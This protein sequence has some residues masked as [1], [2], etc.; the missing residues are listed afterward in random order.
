[1]GLPF[2]WGVSRIGQT[3][4]S[5]ISL[6]GKGFELVKSPHSSSSGVPFPWGV[7]RATRLKFDK[8]GLILVSVC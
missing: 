2:T 7:S 8:Q 1:M 3:G 5:G 6:Q 4:F